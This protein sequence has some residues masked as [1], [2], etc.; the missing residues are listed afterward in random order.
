MQIL[1]S[2]LIYG[3][4][5]VGNRQLWHAVFPM[6]IINDGFCKWWMSRANVQHVSRIITDLNSTTHIIMGY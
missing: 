1:R 5:D 2:K 3:L 6:H 4:D